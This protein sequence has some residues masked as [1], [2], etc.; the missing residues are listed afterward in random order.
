[1]ISSGLTKKERI[2]LTRLKTGHIK[3]MKTDP[4]FCDRCQKSVTAR[5]MNL[6]EQTTEDPTVL[7]FQNHPKRT[8]Q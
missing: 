3:I 4:P 5:Y 8:L 1:M 6:Y 7:T 2:A